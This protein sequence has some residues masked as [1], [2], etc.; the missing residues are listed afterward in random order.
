[1][2]P[3]VFLSKIYHGQFSILFENGT[4]EEKVLLELI[5][6][7]VNNLKR[8]EQVNH[9]LPDFYDKNHLNHIIQVA[10]NKVEQVDTDDV[11]SYYSVDYNSEV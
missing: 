2:D 7:N 6:C 10:E 1:M 3:E 5:S 4:E 11:G 8:Q 9:W